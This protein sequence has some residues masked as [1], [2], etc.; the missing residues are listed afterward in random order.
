[1]TAQGIDAIAFGADRAGAANG[2]SGLWTRVRA[3]GTLPRPGVVVLTLVT[4]AFLI[5]MILVLQL[6]LQATRIATVNELERELS[7]LQRVRSALLVEAATASNLPRIQRRAGELGMQ[8][9]EAGAVFS[10]PPRAVPWV[11]PPPT[12]SDPAPPD[13]PHWRER[14]WHALLLWTGR[15]PAGF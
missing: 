3:A 14:F 12:W 13:A 11:A 5:A 6:Q 1:M 2:V 9:A 4:A 10:P 15:S 7:Q 8:P